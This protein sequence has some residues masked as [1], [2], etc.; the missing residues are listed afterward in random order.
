[1]AIGKVTVE[2][3]RDATPFRCIRATGSVDK[4][5]RAGTKVKCYHHPMHAGEFVLEAANCCFKRVPCVDVKQF[6]L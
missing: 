5:L 4:V 1:M 2:V 3:L 6:V